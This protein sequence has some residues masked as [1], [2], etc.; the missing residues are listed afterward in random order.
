MIDLLR[1]IGLVN[2]AVW[3][4][5]AVYQLLGVGPL[6]TSN[7]LRQALGSA[8]APYFA[9]VIEHLLLSRFF[10]LHLVCGSI[11]ILHAFAEWL[12]LGR[13]PR[14]WWA[15]L[16]GGLFAFN[17]L[18]GLTLNPHLERLHKSRYAVNFTAERRVAA[19]RAYNFWDGAA[20]VLRICILLGTGAYFWRTANQGSLTR[21]ISTAKFRG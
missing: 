6:A 11:A 17:L 7:D 20:G 12:Y 8:N 9:G 15:G 21:F 16:L 3:F 2:G 13:T 10:W 19:A 4:G 14:R 18:I 5:S 1:F